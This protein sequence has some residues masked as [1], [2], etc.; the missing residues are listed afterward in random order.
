VIFCQEIF[1][2]KRRDVFVGGGTLCLLGSSLMPGLVLAQTSVPKAGKEYVRLDRPAPVE[3]NA[4]QVEVVEFFWYNCPHC[5]AFEP[6]LGDWLAKLPKHVAFRRVPVAF[7][8]D[9]EPQQRLY[10][11]LE[12]MGL[13]DKLHAKV[14]AAI[15]GQRLNLN[16]APAIADWVVSQGVDRNKF[17]EQFN[18]FSVATKSKR[19][20]QLQN[21]YGVS[22]VPAMGVAGQFYTDG[23]LARSMAGV[24]DVVN[25]LVA[26]AH[27]GR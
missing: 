27:A 17:T 9:F 18:S 2:M 13:V 12:A 1:K 6:K 20:T 23:E 4:S 14:F 21:L 11:A 8:A 22:G 16:A 15:H 24:L 5:N 3:A 19:A 26:Q 25:F 10:Y 7:R